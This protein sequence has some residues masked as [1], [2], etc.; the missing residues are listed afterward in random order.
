[1]RTSVDSVQTRWAFPV[2]WPVQESHGTL[3]DPVHE[4]CHS[5]LAQ[6]ARLSFL[7]GHRKV[8]TQRCLML[9]ASG[10]DIPPE[11]V[12]VV[13]QVWE[14]LPVWE[15]RR[16]CQAAESWGRFMGRYANQKIRGKQ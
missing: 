4:D 3:S 13:D 5:A 9:E 10:S 16:M 1:M 15:R 14:R 7:K 6:L 11:L 12:A 8:A 2:A